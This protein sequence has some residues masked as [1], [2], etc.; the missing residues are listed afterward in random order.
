MISGLSSRLRRTGRLPLFES[1]RTETGP[2][3]VSEISHRTAELLGQHEQDSEGGVSEATFNLRIVP[4]GNPSD[5][6]LGQTSEAPGVPDVCAH[7]LL[8]PR[9]FHEERISVDTTLN[10]TTKVHCIMNPPRTLLGLSLLL[11]LT[12]GLLTIGCKKDPS[13][14]SYEACKRA[15]KRGNLEI[16]RGACEDA[17]RTDPTT[18]SG[19]AAQRLLKRINTKLESRQPKKEKLPTTITEDWCDQLADRYAE[20]ALASFLAEES[21]KKASQRKTRRYLE[22]IVT[23]DAASKRVYCKDHAGEPMGGY[24]ACIYAAEDL[25]GFQKCKEE[26]RARERAA[27]KAAE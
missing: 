6:F 25:P 24:Y 12:A 16:A 4:Q 21:K 1:R 27:S 8:K 18:Q 9:Q 11:V 19:V 14:P 20:R 13:Q 5:L 2:W 23:D 17:E 26:D 10:P 22:R 15:Y 3:D 7:K